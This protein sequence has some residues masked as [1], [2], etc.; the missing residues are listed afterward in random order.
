MLLND[1]Q[2]RKLIN[3]S[4][5]ISHNLDKANRED[6]TLWSNEMGHITPGASSVLASYVVDMGLEGEYNAVKNLSVEM[7]ID[8]SDVSREVDRQLEELSASYSSPDDFSN[9]LSTH[10]YEEIPDH[11][12]REGKEDEDEEDSYDVPESFEL[13][14]IEDVWGGDPDG[15]GKNLVLPLDHSEAAGSEKVTDSPESE[16]HANPVL[17]KESFGIQVYCSSDGL[18]VPCVLPESLQVGYYQAYT[19]G[20]SKK[21]QIIIENYLNVAFPGWDDYEWTTIKTEKK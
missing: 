13:D 18:G 16:D 10:G 19:S 4:G 9:S 5:G 3:E 1:R 6:Y 2:M 8:P 12:V 20:R 15:E 11:V 14:V 7:G 17:S 21:A